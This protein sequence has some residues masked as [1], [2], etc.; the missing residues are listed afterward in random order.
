MERIFVRKCGHIAN[1]RISLR[2]SLRGPRAKM[3]KVTLD[4]AI[5]RNA[6][7]IELVTKNWAVKVQAG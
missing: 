1:V 6:A 3:Y 5:A 7:V 4:R 2:I